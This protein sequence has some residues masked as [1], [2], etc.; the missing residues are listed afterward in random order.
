M[1]D[2]NRKL[3]RSELPAYWR[4]QL[5]GWSGSG[6]TQAQF[7]REHDLSPAAFSWWKAK[8]RDELNLPHRCVRKRAVK[9]D[10]FI[11][12]HLPE[13]PPV[14][15]TPR[16]ELVLTN[17]RRITVPNRFD[18]EVLERLIQVAQKPC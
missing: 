9:K 3:R 2:Q 11:E 12:L 16:C 17:G 6:L 18:P 10:R 13:A 7:C 15:G 8:L 1:D 5:L 4:R 14:A